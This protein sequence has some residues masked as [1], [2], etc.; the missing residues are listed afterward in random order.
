MCWIFGYIGDKN[1]AQKI[2]IHWL[3]R[4]EYR[5]YDSA[6][7]F[8][9]NKS[10]KTKLIKA[11][12][13]VSNLANKMYNSLETNESWN[14]GIA[15]TR[16]AT[17]WWISEENTHPHYDNN[18]NFHIVHNW[19]IE[20]YHQLKEELKGKWYQF[21]SET[22]S[23]VIANLLKYL[24]NWDF[25]E[26]VEKVLKKIRGAYALLILSK[27]NPNEMIAVRLWSPLI[28]AYDENNDFYFSSDKQALSGYVDKF[29]YMDDGDILHIKDKDYKI[30]AN[31]VNVSR[32]IEDMDIKLLESSKWDFKHFMLKEIFEQATI[33][34]RIFKWRVN[35]ENNTMNTDAFHGMKDE[36]FTKIIFVWCWTSY[37]AWVLWTYYMENLVWLDSISYIASEYEY[38]NIKVNDETLFVF[39]S[40]SWE[41]AD[42]I[43]VLKL[44]KAKWAKTFWIVNVVGS[45]ISRL[46]DYWLFTRAGAEIWVASTKAFTAQITC[47]ILLALFLWQKRWLSK[48]KYDQV[49]SALNDVPDK[50][51]QVLN[52]HLEIKKIAEEIAKHK[53][54]FFLWRHYQLSI[55]RESSLK[56][57]EITYLHSEFYP[58]WE[59][60]HWP[61]ALVD[62]N[63]PSVL[64]LPKDI[65]F[66]RN[67]SSI[68][69]IKARK[70]KVLIISDEEVESSDFFI[71]IPYCIDE[72]YPF[73]TAV[74]GQLLAYYSADFLNKDIDKP[75]NL[76]KS[77][78][79]K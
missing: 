68:Q 7:I 66:E 57:K 23:E 70:W 53:N 41:T 49:M 26:T 4:L 58:T 6:G 17:H 30:K 15:H 76:A 40:Q 73:V 64:F 33:I 42:S 71:K 25:L 14:F 52:S 5:W 36:K 13:K 16:W 61:L 43:E 8:V 47:I 28:F 59:L 34:K 29:I 9:G 1:D 44:L 63:V 35:F 54:F 19:I 67:L 62:E 65:L 46:T 60:K 48:A 27:M 72:T 74:V 69:E 50:I 78:T 3:E 79:V 75:R 55:A 12:W 45:T 56:F 77:V 11:I 51:E 22:D 31:G 18:K 24:W 38:Q 2:L 20:N 32:K 21:Y 37:N 10:W 39:I